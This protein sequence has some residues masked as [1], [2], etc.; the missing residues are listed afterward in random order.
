M[1]KTILSVLLSFV[2]SNFGCKEAS[3]TPPPDEQPATWQVIPELASLD[4]RY[5]I[6]H[7]GVLYMAGVDLNKSVGADGYG[8]MY[9]TKDAVTWEKIRSQ[10]KPLGPIAFHQDTLYCLGDSL[11]R[12]MP[13]IGPGVSPVRLSGRPAT[14]APCDTAGSPG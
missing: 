13:S 11:Y 12:W 7:N 14:E 3:T 10:Q 8:V 2:L 5:M 4:V 1:L 6:Q 9:Q